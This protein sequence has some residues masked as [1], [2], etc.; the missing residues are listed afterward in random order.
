MIGLIVPIAV[1]VSGIGNGWELAAFAVG[2]ALVVELIGWLS[3]R[4]TGRDAPA[5]TRLLTS[6]LI[7]RA[8][9]S[10]LLLVPI[11]WG[12]AGMFVPLVGAIIGYQVAATR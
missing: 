1:Y 9:G 6:V 10:A 7:G 11:A 12:V 5:L 8:I 2:Y 4:L 3:V